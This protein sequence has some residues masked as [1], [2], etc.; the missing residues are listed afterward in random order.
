MVDVMKQ[1]N[2]IW[3]YGLSGSGKSFAS[4]V[5]KE[6][7]PNA[8]VVDGDDVRKYVSKDLSYSKN[9]RKVQTNRILGISKIVIQ[10]KMFP[11]I[12]TVTMQSDLL[13]ECNKLQIEVV[14]LSRP[15]DQI[16]KVREIYKNKSN[17]VG[18][19]IAFKKFDT[20]TLAN[21]GTDKFEKL[22]RELFG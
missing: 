8:F 18:K 10:N 17:V 11:I 15:M 2:G 6:F 4:S 5:C 7:I 20:R 19:D 13:G 22:L 21:D 16:Y 12:S 3:F 14:L 9:D 1:S